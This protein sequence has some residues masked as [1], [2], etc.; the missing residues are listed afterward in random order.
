M[1]K[2][3]IS[4][5]SEFENKIAYFR[6]VVDSDFVSGPEYDCTTMTIF[7]RVAEQLDQ[8]LKNIKQG[9]EYAGIDLSGIFR[10]RYILPSKADF[11]PHWPV[12]QKHFG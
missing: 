10:R 12:L 3:L 6:A 2:Q 9:L 4:N 11:E 8:C 7:E 1:S 5:G